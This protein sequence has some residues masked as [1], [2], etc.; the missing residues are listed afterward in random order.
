VP[1][2][3]ILIDLLPCSMAI[4][5]LQVLGAPREPSPFRRDLVW[6]CLPA[7]ALGLTITLALGVRLHLRAFVG[8]VL[9]ASVGLRVFGRRL[10]W[11]KEL[12]T[13]ASRP[14]LATIGLIHG[15]TNLG[16]GPLTALVASRFEDKQAVRA[17]V[18]FGYLF[19]AAAQLLVLGVTRAVSV[20]AAQLYLPALAVAVYLAVGN[21]LFRAAQPNAYQLGMTGLL[22]VLA[23]LLFL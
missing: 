15:M 22:G 3:T 13:S 20:G 11:W 23:V 4:N 17:N 21:R 7:V 1:F 16:G 19:M 6:F 8:V 14:L 9:L 5:V 2:P 10:A 12:T 18:A